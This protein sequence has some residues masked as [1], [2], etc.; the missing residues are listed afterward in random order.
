L[1]RVDE[2]GARLQQTELLLELKGAR[3]GSRR[4][5]PD[6]VV[7]HGDIAHQAA[8]LPLQ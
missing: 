6:S 5:K 8:M 2:K 4:D 3:R 1:L 7:R